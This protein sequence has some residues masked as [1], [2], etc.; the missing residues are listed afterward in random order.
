MEPTR[1]VNAT[2]VDLLDRVLD[3]GLLINADI[4]ISVA[5]IPLIGVNLK[6][7]IAGMETMLEYGMMKDWDLAQRAIA[8]EER[9]LI[10]PILTGNE[11]IIT[12]TFASHYYSDGIYKAWRTGQLYITN[13][14]IVLFRKE[15]YEILFETNFKRI[16]ILR[17][18]KRENTLDLHIYLRNNTLVE[19]H[20]K[21]IEELKKLIQNKIKE[22][23][24]V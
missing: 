23:V 4:I 9:K 1:E 3:K 13:K 24:I 8:R 2:L 7:A 18:K 20:A 17:T 15:P 6:A 22:P 19:L 14:R 12:K 16:R 11:K 5:D 10:S 21:N